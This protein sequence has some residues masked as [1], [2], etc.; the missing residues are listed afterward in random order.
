VVS[1]LPTSEAKTAW[2][3]LRFWIEDDY[4]DGK[5]GWFHW[6]HSK[7]SKPE[8][9][10][11]LWLVLAIAM[12]K[13]VL[14]GGEL[15]AQEQ[16]AQRK[17]QRRSRG[18]KRRR[19]RP[20]VPQ[21]RPRG[22]EQSVIMRGVMAM[23]ARETGGKKSLPPGWVRAEPLPRR[24]Y[25]VSRVPRS[26]QLKKQ[27]RAQKKRQRQRADRELK[28]A[29][30]VQARA[31]HQ[32]EQQVRRQAKHAAV[33]AHRHEQQAHRQAK[34]AV[35]LARQQEQQARRQAKHARLLADGPAKAATH[36]APTTGVAQRPGGT[37]G[38]IDLCSN[39]LQISHGRLSTCDHQQEAGQPEACR[40]GSA[41]APVSDMP[42]AG[43]PLLRLSRGRLQPPHKPMRT[44]I[45]HKR[46]HEPP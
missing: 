21:Q 10:S 33:L 36:Q 3:Q 12:Q 11:R 34:H 24:L 13:A 7:M 9:A 44:E 31:A 28:R 20:A 42:L 27:R 5:R 19:G 4:K 25:G 22:R 16:E 45:H 8:R 30:R 37:R 38:D 6:E 1:D 40:R 18:K 17:K 23:R 43:G 41:R 2:Y 39:V 46:A 35:A 15:E 14:L 26:Y 29:Q 32:A